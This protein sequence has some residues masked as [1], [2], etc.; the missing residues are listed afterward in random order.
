M[1]RPLADAL[2]NSS[3]EEVNLEATEADGWIQSGLMRI[4]LRNSSLQRIVC[5]GI[6]YEKTIRQLLQQACIS[7]AD[8]QKFMFIHDG[9]MDDML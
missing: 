4:L 6:T 7:D 1:D 3:I 2:G 5:R 9:G 8:V